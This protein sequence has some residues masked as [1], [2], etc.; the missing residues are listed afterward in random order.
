[1]RANALEFLDNILQPQ[2]RS[3]IVPLLDSQVSVRERVAL[4]NRLLG[5]S[6]ETPEQAVSA[7]VASDD[8]WMRASGAYAIG[9]L[10]L[11]ALAPELDRL[12]ATTDDPLLRETVRAAQEKLTTTPKPPVPAAEL[13]PVRETWEAEQQ[14]MGIG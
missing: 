7:L 3:L 4:A 14:S 6:V 5:T 10:R 12:A 11:T 2:V 1:M 8:P 9:M 13:T